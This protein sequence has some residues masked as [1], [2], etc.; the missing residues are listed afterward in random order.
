MEIDHVAIAVRDID[1]AL[2]F[3][4]DCLGLRLI[5]DEVL[6][7]AGVRLVYL[8]GGAALLQLVQ[9]VAPCPVA[10]YL[11]AHGEGL[12]HLCFAVD[13]IPDA[14]RAL[15]GQDGV[16]V[17]M[18]GRGR[19]ACFLAAPPNGLRIELTEVAPYQ[20]QTAEAAP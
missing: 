20:S 6:A 15:P 19:R 12:H 8:A 11:A 1:A 4:V 2:P 17:V 7:S 13:D 10:E 3:Y 5:H 14:L 16:A 18:G 9:P